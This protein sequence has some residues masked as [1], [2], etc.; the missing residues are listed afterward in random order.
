MS[1]PILNQ[2]NRSRWMDWKPR[3]RILADSTESEP[4]KPSK[5]GSVGFVGAI[6][7]ESSEIRGKAHAAELAF[8]DDSPD[9]VR[10]TTVR[11]RA[12]SPLAA[13]RGQRAE[14]EPPG[15]DW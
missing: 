7:E 12:A 11:T 2:E 1:K 4:T 14:F 10:E 8:V 6:L 9:A 3:A 5:P 13:E 15:L